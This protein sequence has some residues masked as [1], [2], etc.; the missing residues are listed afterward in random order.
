MLRCA[1]VLT[2]FAAL[3]AQAATIHVPGD[4]PTIQQ[5]IDVADPMDTILVEPGTY[6]ENIVIWQS[7]H[8]VANTGGGGSAVIIDGGLAAAT[9]T[10]TGVETPETTL[11]GFTVQN[12]SDVYGGGIAGNGTHAT[13]S[14]CLIT[15]NTAD[16]GGGLFNCDGIIQNCRITWNTADS[17]GGLYRCDGTVLHCTIENNTAARGA[18]LYECQGTVS[19]CGILT[20]TATAGSGAGAYNCNGSLSE[21]RIA[22]NTNS[23]TS[24]YYTG[25]G[26]YD[27]DGPITRCTI[28]GNSASYASGGGAAVCDGTFSRCVIR[29]NVCKYD[30]GG[31]LN[32]GGPIEDCVV[33]G[34]RVTGAAYGGGLANCLGTIRNCTVVGNRAFDGG[35]LASCGT[36]TNCIVWN[37][38]PTG[39]SY[40]QVRLPTAVSY[41][42]VQDGSAWPG[43]ITAAP[44]FVNDGLWSGTTWQEGDYHLSATSPCVNTA[45]P[46]FASEGTDIEGNPR[47]V[48]GRVD[49][50][51]YERD[52]SGGSLPDFDGDGTPDRTD[53]DMDNDTVANEADVCDFTPAGATVQGNGTLRADL[54]GDCDAD[55]L[56]FAILELELTGPG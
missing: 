28:E 13:I 54:D 45:D 22:G 1:F 32:C 25:G 35:G 42:D 44:Q 24:T 55:L 38:R 18:G 49:M 27:C 37:N 47:V 50:G 9:V 48:G 16:V 20:N 33:S 30:G 53:P 43:C 21:C 10:F 23:G 6:T 11:E 26:L 17:G 29:T 51:A 39:G 2:L 8:L 31:L 19:S 34:N 36:I 46:G 40:Q 5:A 15:D 4:H 3:P 56:D 41:C 12:G 7:V 52:P 14:N